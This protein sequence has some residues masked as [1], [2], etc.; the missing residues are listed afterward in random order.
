MPIINWE[1]YKYLL[2]EKET[3]VVEM[4][5]RGC[6]ALHIQSNQDN[7]EISPWDNSEGND[8]RVTDMHLKCL[9]IPFTSI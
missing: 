4:V 8:S 9:I 1:L 6:I 5:R 2:N 3:V 7:S